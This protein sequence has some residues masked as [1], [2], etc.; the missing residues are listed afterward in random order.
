MMETEPGGYLQWVEV[1]IPEQ[2]IVSAP[3]DAPTEQTLR[4]SE[5]GKK[6]IATLGVDFKCVPF[7]HP[8]N[9][10]H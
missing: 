4:F 2:K 1:N 5:N 10:G 9:T 8:H 6:A 7:S 3:A